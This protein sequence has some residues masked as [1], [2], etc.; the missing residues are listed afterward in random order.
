MTP[1]WIYYNVSLSD[2]PQ[3]RNLVVAKKTKKTGK[4]VRPREA[5]DPEVPELPSLLPATRFPDAVFRQKDVLAA[6]RPLG[7]QGALGWAG[8]VEAASSVQAMGAD[9][10]DRGAADKYGGGRGARER[11][12]ALLTYLDTHEARLFDLKKETSGLFRRMAK[13]VYTDPAA[14]ER[15][16]ERLAALHKLMA[17]SWVRTGG[18]AGVPRVWRSLAGGGGLFVAGPKATSLSCSCHILSYVTQRPVRSG[19]LAKS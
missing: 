12:R 6:L 5:F 19:Q 7:L 15:G 8:L 9:D 3:T 4:L 16:R 10:G 18:S 2:S 13:L 1:H 17:L 14:E 11:G